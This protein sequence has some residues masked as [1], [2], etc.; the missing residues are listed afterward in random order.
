MKYRM[1]QD[2][3]QISEKHLNQLQVFT[4]NKNTANIKLEEKEVYITINTSSY[5]L[6]RFIPQA[7]LTVKDNTELMRDMIKQDKIGQ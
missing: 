2:E 3:F 6:T 5:E 4:I 7:V 1:L